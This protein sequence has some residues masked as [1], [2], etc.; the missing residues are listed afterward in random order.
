MDGRKTKT[1]IKKDGPDRLFQE[2]K[3]P[4]TGEVLTTVVREVINDQLVQV[5]Q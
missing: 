5:N 4:I 3:D 1:V 2:Q